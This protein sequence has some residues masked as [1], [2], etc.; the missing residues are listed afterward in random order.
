MT[1]LDHFVDHDFTMTEDWH[2]VPGDNFE[3]RSFVCDGCGH[4]M[5]ERRDS[6][7]LV[8]ASTNPITDTR[9]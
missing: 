9:S 7:G 5:V 4:V 6:T 3:Q 2:V 8:P 1:E